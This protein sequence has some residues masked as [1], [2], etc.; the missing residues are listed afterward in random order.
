MPM[1]HGY[2][3]LLRGFVALRVRFTNRGDGG[4][5]LVEYA[6]LVALI[7]LVAI[8]AVTFFGHSTSSKMEVPPSMFG[9]G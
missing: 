8:G 7:T 3:H 6:L 4:T 1:S 5:G 9:S 2:E